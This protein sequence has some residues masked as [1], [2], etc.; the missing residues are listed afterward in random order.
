MPHLHVGLLSSI[1]PIST[2]R[3]VSRTTRS[4]DPTWPGTRAT[5]LPSEGRHAAPARPAT[6]VTARV[7]QRRAR[8]GCRDD[9][10]P[11][12][13]RA[14]LRGVHASARRPAAPASRAGRPASPASCSARAAPPDARAAARASPRGER[15]A[16]ARRS[17]PT[18]ARAVRGL[19]R[20]AGEHQRLLRGQRV[21]DDRAQAVQPRA[22]IGVGQRLAARHLCDAA[23]AREHRPRRRNATPRGRQ[24]ATHRRLAAAGHTHDDDDD[25]GLQLRDST[26]S[27]YASRNT[28]GGLSLPR[29]DPMPT[30]L[31]GRH[32]LGMARRLKIR[33][34]RFA[35]FERRAAGGRRVL[36][37]YLLRH[38]ETE[39]S[40]GDR[41]CGDID[42]PLT[43]AG[44]LM[45]EQF[46]APTR[47]LRWRAIVTSTR[48]RAQ[49]TAEPLAARTRARIRRDPPPG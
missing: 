39:F 32:G 8:R 19:Q 22:A 12:A 5:G 13:R 23:R 38:G 33:F 34:P 37:L 3:M 35:R 10:A 21:D 9:P 40:R 14:G 29:Q 18:S 49:A 41:F 44:M 20:R 6:S 4:S 1:D 24:R 36:K 11:P 17:P 43:D 27:S 31:R 48:R 28:F 45:G 25:R 16:R 46:A 2:R 26:R 7:T 30:T 15:H 47:G 42:A